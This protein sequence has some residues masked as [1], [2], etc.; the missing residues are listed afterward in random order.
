MR[1]PPEAPT[2]YPDGIGRGT[3]G[4][5]ILGLMS[6]EIFGP[7][8]RALLRSAGRVAAE[9]LA[10]VGS[11]LAPGVTTAEIDRWVR[12]DTARRGG[13]PGQLGYKGFPGTTDIAAT[14]RAF[15]ARAA[16]S[17]RARARVR[18]CLRTEG[19][20]AGELPVRG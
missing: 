14:G 4:P 5:R 1:A 11:R 9:T 6:I 3:P 19:E 12:E 8:Q 13:T 15:R 7:P 16:H 17:A 20:A 2:S 18:G 10:D